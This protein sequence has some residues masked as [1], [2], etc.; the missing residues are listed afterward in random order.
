MV[1]YFGCHSAKMFIRGKPICFVY[2][3]WCLC[4]SDGYPFLMQIYQEKQS[5]A[6]NQ[7]LGLHVINNMV[8]LIFNNSNVPHRLLYFDNFLTS[9]HLMIELAEKSVRTTVTILENR[10]ER[11]NK[12]LVESKEL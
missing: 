7:P 2:K 3:I 4:E 9:D 11:V 1:P 10:A 5:N 8:S 6:I 12:E